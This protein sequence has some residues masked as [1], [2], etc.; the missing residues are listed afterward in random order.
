MA[1]LEPEIISEAEADERGIDQRSK[2][3]KQLA[4]QQKIEIVLT[5]D[6]MRA[7]KDQWAH[8]DNSQPAEITFVVEGTVNSKF[9]VAAYG[10]FSTKCCG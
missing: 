6:Q 7:L 5:A 2:Q 10:Y 8:A 9:Q 3:I 1:Y 4:T